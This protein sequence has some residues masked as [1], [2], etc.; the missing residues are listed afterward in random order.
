MIKG[1]PKFNAIAVG[2]LHADFTKTTTH[3]EGTAGFVDNETGETHGWTKG[4]GKVWSRTTMLKLKELREAMERDLAKLHFTDGSI[5]HEGATG[6]RGLDLGG[7]AEHAEG[8]KDA[9]SV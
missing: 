1:A 7:I 4:D 5:E 6:K 8:P 9:P 2:E 3:L